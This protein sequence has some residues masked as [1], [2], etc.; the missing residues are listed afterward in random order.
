MA[1]LPV[2][3]GWQAVRA[4][5]RAGFEVRRR[6]GSHIIMG[7]SGHAATLSVPGH[8]ELKPGT[9]RALLRKG[10]LSVEQFVEMLGRSGS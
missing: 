2:V 9:L 5:E 7:K 10:G 4:F 8:R 1:K 6:E 3:S